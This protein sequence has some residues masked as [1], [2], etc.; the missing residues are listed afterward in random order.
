VSVALYYVSFGVMRFNSTLPICTTLL[1][2]ILIVELRQVGWA[3]VAADLRQP[4][5]TIRMMLREKS[6]LE[7]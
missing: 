6:K 1:F 5:R 3:V 4:L 7:S 2:G